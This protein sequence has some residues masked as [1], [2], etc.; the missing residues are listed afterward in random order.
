[1]NNGGV[2]GPS[3]R[4][5]VP[6]VISETKLPTVT[7]P[8][9][10]GSGQ[11]T[12]SASSETLGTFK[13]Y[14][15]LTAPA[16]DTLRTAK[17]TKTST[18]SPSL[19][20]S[21]TF[22]VSF[23]GDCETARV[24]VTAS[25]DLKADFDWNTICAGSST[26]FVDKT[27]KAAGLSQSLTY[28][29]KFTGDS[30][31]ILTTPKGASPDIPILSI[32][33]KNGVIDGTYR[34][35]KFIYKLPN[36]YKVTFTVS[37]TKNP[38][39]KDEVIK[40]VKILETKPVTQ[41]VEWPLQKGKSDFGWFAESLAEGVPHD[42]K[43][44]SS[45][46][47]PTM[48]TS[49]S[50]WWTKPEPIANSYRPN[51]SSVVNLNKCLDISGLKRP[52]ISFNYWS[53]FESNYDGAVAQYSTDEGITWNLLKL[54]TLTDGGINWFNSSRILADI[55]NQQ[56]KTNPISW[57]WTGRSVDWRRAA[58]NLDMIPKTKAKSVRFRIAMASGATNADDGTGKSYQ[59]FAF[60]SVYIGEKKRQV[61]VEH[62]SEPGDAASPSQLADSYLDALLKRQEQEDFRGAGNADFNS[63]RYYLK[64]RGS[65]N[66]DHPLSLDNIT[67]P[68]QRAAVHGV[69]SFPAT[70]MGGRSFERINK[71][72]FNYKDLDARALVP[73]KFTLQLEASKP[74]DTKLKITFT[75]TSDFVVTS[76]VVAQ[77]ALVENNVSETTRY[78]V[79]TYQNVLRRLLLGSDATKRDG[80][81]ISAN[82]FGTIGAKKTIEKTVE[83]DT[84]ILNENNLKLIGFVQ[85]NFTGE[86]YQSVLINAPAVKGT[87][88]PITAV[89]DA[90]EP[91]SLDMYPNP[92]ANGKLYLAVPQEFLPTGSWKIADQRGVFVEQG[93]FHNSSEGVKAVDVSQLANGVYF[94]WMSAAGKTP[95]Y[96]KLVVI[97]RY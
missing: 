65:N 61:L 10:C 35:P 46:I 39:C 92:V 3:Q 44:T 85:D 82:T 56:Q 89:D 63:I 1:F 52:M 74:S 53:D 26:T 73:P 30:K 20:N 7:A 6:V 50:T 93:D 94:V 14:K 29:W 78:G 43:D 95:I 45:I 79:R 88:D 91:H 27:T 60:N 48:K 59:G 71:S 32:D 41:A 28:T 87:T 47:G 72:N 25:I 5:P 81:N 4:V 84:Y 40:S 21:E 38:D 2:C 24:P 86:T 62:F 66:T 75:I 64:G 49:D 96:R 18:Y 34:N 37:S 23:T 15:S 9:R 90:L 76:P 77:V 12:L 42:W 70:F 80:E 67:D 33:K 36:D 69:T 57:G 54:D 8:S 83:I 17:N 31:D 58:Y 55:G 11:I 19:T 68:D 22:Y 13:W 16:R 51:Q 97:N